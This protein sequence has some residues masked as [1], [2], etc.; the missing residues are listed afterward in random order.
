MR[1]FLPA[2]NVAYNTAAS[3]DLVP[4]G[5]IGLFYMNDGVTTALTAANVANCK[6]KMFQ[7]VLGRA[8]AHGG[9]TILALHKNNFSYSKMVAEAPTKFK[10]E[11]T[12]GELVEM[13]D[14][15]VIFV[16]KG[17]KFN[18]R[19]NWTATVHAT[20]GTETPEHVAAEI[21]KFVNTNPLLGLVAT[22]AGTKITV[23]ATEFGVDYNIVPADALFGTEVTFMSKGTKGWGTVAH[24]KELAKQAAA[25]AGFNDT[26]QDD[27]ALLYPNYPYDPMRTTAA[28]EPTFVIYTL[29]FAVPRAV[30]TRDEVVNQIVQIAV[31]TGAAQ[32]GA[33]DTIFKALAE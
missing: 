31:P 30:K 33:L 1:Q 5:A 11:F 22:V 17:V 13:E 4:A 24:V 2:G 19:S 3:P 27:A 15:S 29:R 32:I 28:T 14:H 8:A 16:K 12:I 18:E 10:A 20:L 25:D 26:Y 9:P 23:E 7:L 6:E 21:G